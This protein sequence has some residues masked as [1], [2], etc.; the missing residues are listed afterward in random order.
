[1]SR[2]NSFLRFPR[3]DQRVLGYAGEG[4]FSLDTEWVQAKDPCPCRNCYSG[5]DD[6]GGDPEYEC[7]IGV[8]RC[9]DCGCKEMVRE[10]DANP[11]LQGKVNVIV[12]T[13]KCKQC[14]K[15]IWTITRRQTVDVY[16]IP[17]GFC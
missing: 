17:H 13:N 11:P 14:G 16:L 6:E 4:K 15:V 3:T 8:K 1:M 2:E 12:Q 7:A 5:S 9:F 10:G